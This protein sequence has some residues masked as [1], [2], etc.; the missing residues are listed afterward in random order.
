M[1]FIEA[2]DPATLELLIQLQALPAFSSLRLVRGTGLALQ[3]GHRISIDIDLFGNI[4]ADEFEVVNQLK[5][6][7]TPTVLKKSKNINIFIINGIKVDIVNY[8]YPWLAPP[9]RENNLTIA[10]IIDIAAM[11]LSAITGR[12]T[13]KDFIDLFFLL[14]LY[15]L[16]QL[17]NFY[18]QKYPDGSEFLVIKSLTYFDDAEDDDFPVMLVDTNWQAVKQRIRN[19][20]KQ[21]LELGH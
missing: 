14:K 1:L 3:I 15:S 19:A 10:N 21:F 5:S 6:I 9:L 2:I 12:G 17:L 13:R 11:K 20:V 4:K 8:P 7:A 16:N 18:K